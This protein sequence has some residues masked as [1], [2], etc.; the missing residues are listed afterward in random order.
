VLLLKYQDRSA[1]DK[2]LINSAVAHLA[3]S[4]RGTEMS[5]Y[6]LE[7]G[8][9]ACH[10]IAEN[11]E[12]TDW[13]QILSYYDILLS[14]NNSPI[15][16]LNRSVAVGQ[17]SGPAAGLESIAGL[18]GNKEIQGYYLFHAIRGEFYQEL[19]EFDRAVDNFERALGLTTIPAER[20]LL[21]QKILNCVSNK[22]HSLCT[23]SI[24][25]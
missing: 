2:Q 23:S 10:C 9:A 3:E 20:E 16:R 8:I 21:K 15:I 12:T 18:D 7:A 14:I 13:R 5:Q 1:W 4:A 22:A 11:F 19:G 25:A 17:V 6:H 24:I